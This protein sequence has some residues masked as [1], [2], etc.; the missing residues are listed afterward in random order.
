MTGS[1]DKRCFANKEFCINY[2]CMELSV[3][4]HE[5]KYILQ[6]LSFFDELRVIY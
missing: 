1:P 5:L 3:K 4:K 2:N 6:M